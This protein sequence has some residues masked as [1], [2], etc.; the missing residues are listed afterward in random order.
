MTEAQALMALARAQRAMLTLTK[1]RLKDDQLDGFTRAAE[2]KKHSD[3][4]FEVRETWRSTGLITEEEAME[5]DKTAGL[6]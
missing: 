5:A 3:F 2:A 1:Q 6:N 4:Y